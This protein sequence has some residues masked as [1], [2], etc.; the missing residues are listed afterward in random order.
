MDAWE[1]TKVVF[2]RVRVLDPDNASKIMGMLL[3]QHDSDE[4]E[5]I[6]R[7]ANG[8]DHLLHAFVATA[9]ADLTTT[10]TTTKPA[11]PPSPP[12]GVSRLGGGGHQSPFTTDRV[13]HEYDGGDAF[14]C[15]EGEAD[16]CWSPA[17]GGHRRRSFPP[18]DAEV[19]AWRKP[20]MYFARGYCKYGSS[21]RF[22][23]C[24]SGDDAAAEREMAVMRAEASAAARSQQLTATS[25]IP[26]SPSPPKGVSLDSLL[27]H[28]QHE[29]Q[30]CHFLPVIKTAF[31]GFALVPTFPDSR[32]CF[33]G[34]RRRRRRRACCSAARTCAGS[35][36]GHLGWTAASSPAARRRHS[37]ST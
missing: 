16:D 13:G 17:G 21:C 25:A 24:L 11:P 7:L 12:V 31:F 23:H 8:P 5:L 9:R 14:Y 18:S 32:C 15:P 36:C 20:C 35:R 10:T 3:I 2:D 30:R 26:F 1:A 4:E 22:L 27:Q 37:R 29:H 34:R 33:S 19:A 28:H 6:V